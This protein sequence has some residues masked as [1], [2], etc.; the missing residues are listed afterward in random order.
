MVQTSGSSVE[1]FEPGF[2]MFALK[3]P[4]LHSS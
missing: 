3:L 1:A 4:A 2:A